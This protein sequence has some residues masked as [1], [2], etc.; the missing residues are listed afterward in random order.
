MWTRRRFLTVA[1]SAAA[2]V[3]AG[4]GFGRAGTS[5]S[6]PTPGARPTGPSAPATASSAVAT[7]ARARADLRQ[8]VTARAVTVDDPW[9]L[10]HAVLPLG[11]E[12]RHGDELVIDYVTR[13]FAE[14]RTAGGNAYPM[15]PVNVEAHPNHFLEIMYATGVEPDR[16]FP[17][18][19]GPITRRDLYAGAKTLFS[20]ATVSDELAWTVSI[21]TAEM[22]PGADRFENGDG[23]TFSV[24]ALVETA[25]QS[26]E[27][28][29]ADTVAA[30][31]GAKP[32]GRSALQGCACNG[33][34]A[35][36]GLLDAL[37]NGYRANE[38]AA[39]VTQLMHAALFRLGP[40]SA[41][42]DQMIGR[43]GA[44]SA[45]LNA[46][47]AKLQFLGHSI[48]NL[49]FAERFK[50]YQPSA[51]ESA[52]VRA[53]EEELAAVAHRM[54]AVYDLDGL[55]RQVPRAYRTILGDACHALRGL[56]TPSR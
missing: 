32:Y 29:Y 21:F 8:L 34:H 11:P 36:Y 10:M 15:F 31:R 38:L 5:R 9:T 13:T 40:E 23:R 2:S 48:E 37:R 45:T 30:M 4:A 49:R 27:G 56:E 16:P 20:P 24:S 22:R 55:A 7:L 26:A 47:A 51:D 53:A 43:G 18:K 12:V 54:V 44:P 39:R 35:I 1:G 6:E 17:S 50:V 41:L 19:A 28:L 25:A 52:R 3:V 33:T 14:T 42:I 46:D